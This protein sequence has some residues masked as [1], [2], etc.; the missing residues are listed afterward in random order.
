LIELGLEGFEFFEC[1]AVFVLVIVDFEVARDELVF[2][3]VSDGE[4]IV[5]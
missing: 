4:E 3:V 2:D 5:G 1:F